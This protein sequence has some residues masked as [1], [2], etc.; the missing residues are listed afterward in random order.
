MLYGSECCRRNSERDPTNC[1]IPDLIRDPLPTSIRQPVVRLKRHRP[2]QRPLPVKIRF[3]SI[4][5][6]FLH[7]VFI[8]C[9]IWRRLSSARA[10]KTASLKRHEPNVSR[11]AEMSGSHRPKSELARLNQQSASC[12]PGAAHHNLFPE[13]QSRS[14]DHAG[15]RS[16][17]DL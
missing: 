12:S 10:M 3:A 11:F 14:P 15:I 5:T 1:V 8:A 13:F 6:D 4:S 17:S 7:Y 9:R 16:P 2:A